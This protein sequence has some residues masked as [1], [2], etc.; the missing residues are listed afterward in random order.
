MGPNN[1]L[2]KIP[3][4]NFAAYWMSDRTLLIA[5]FEKKRTVI[6]IDTKLSKNSEDDCKIGHSNYILFS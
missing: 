6:M 2:N 4:L 5:S 1:F 3:F